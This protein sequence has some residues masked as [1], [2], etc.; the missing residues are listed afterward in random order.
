MSQAYTAT[1]AGTDDANTVLKTT[2]PNN[3]AALASCFS[4]ASAPATTFAYMTWFDTT[5]KLVKVRNAANSDWVIFGPLLG[6][7]GRILRPITFSTSLSATTVFA[8][9]RMPCPAVIYGVNIASQAT[10]SGSSAGVTEWQW[11]LR[12]VT[13]G[14]NLFS[15][16]VGTGTSLGGVGGGEITLDASYALLADQNAA[17]AT[18]DVLRFTATKV[19]SP[20]TLTNVVV[21][22]HG[23]EVGT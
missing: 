3:F 13:G 15:G 16:T 21:E 19:G 22:L 1:I 18:G 8:W 14:V 11:A 6:T 17:V 4:G 9:P 2:I 5:N 12:N 7:A 10:S 23:Y 20:T